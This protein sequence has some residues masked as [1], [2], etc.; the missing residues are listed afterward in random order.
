[1][2]IE[3]VEESREDRHCKGDVCS[4]NVGPGS[5]SDTSSRMKGP[6]FNGE[7]RSMMYYEI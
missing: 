4:V 3:E 1:M 7:R 6:L 5:V 2:I